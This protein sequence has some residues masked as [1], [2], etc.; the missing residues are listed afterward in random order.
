MQNRQQRF[1]NECVGQ[2]MS[3]MNSSAFKVHN[4]VFSGCLSTCEPLALGQLCTGDGCFPRWDITKGITDSSFALPGNLHILVTRD[5]AIPPSSVMDFISSR[6][7][8][9]RRSK[10]RNKSSS[11]VWIDIEATILGSHSGVLGQLLV[12]RTGPGIKLLI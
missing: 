7:T 3:Q 8:L 1:G 11:C 6:G 9:R 5:Y 12:L 2:R 4:P 10:T